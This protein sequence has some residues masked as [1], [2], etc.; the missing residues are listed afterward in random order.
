MPTDLAAPRRFDPVAAWFTALC[1]TLA[2]YAIMGKGFA[3]LGA[4]P[5]FVGEALLLTGAMLLLT[6]PS[7]RKLLESPVIWWLLLLS[8]WGLLRTL[9][10]VGQYKADALRDAVIFGYGAFTFIV[11]AWL[12]ARPAM[13]GVLLSRYQRYI[14]VFLMVIPVLWLM[15]Q[16][17]HGWFPRWPWANVAILHLKAA[18]ILVH[19]GGMAALAVVGLFPRHHMVWVLLVLVNVA[20]AGVVNRGGLVSF[21]FVVLLAFCFYP[22][23]NWVRRMFVVGMFAII[24]LAAVNPEIETP[25]DRR[26][27]SFDQLS[28]N[29]ISLFSNVKKG[30]LDGT[31]QWRLDWWGKIVDYTVYGKYFWTGK[32]YG[33]NL[34]DSDGFQVLDDGSLRSPHNGH[35]T[36][37][38]RSGVPG[39]AIWIGLHACFALTML[40]AIRRASMQGDQAWRRLFVFILAYWCGFMINASFDVFI[41]GPM[42]GVWFWSLMGLGVA[43]VWVYRRDPGAANLEGSVQRCV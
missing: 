5:L 35:L 10:Y 32:G 40:N 26:R 12:I 27:I 31:K 20:L 2:G 29:V 28:T 36:V 3:Y 41:E 38:A 4:P 37:L 13:I 9:P 19:L 11:A 15:Q 43:S 7:W 16:L 22:Q 39:M 6:C 1:F 34:A 18:D 33:I 23:S 24:A 30:D 8:G 14:P 42:G 25:S 17:L 21:A